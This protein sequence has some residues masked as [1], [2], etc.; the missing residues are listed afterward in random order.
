MQIKGGV[1]MRKGF[2][3]LAAIFFLVVAASIGT[4]ALSIA[5]TS[6]RQS[7]EIYLREQAQLIAQS[8]AEYAIYEIFRTNFSNK[9]LDKVSG[10]FNDMFDFNVDIT[11]FGDI[12]I[13]TPPTV[14]SGTSG[15]A[16]TGN[17]MLDV[18]VTS[19]PG[20]ALNPINFHKRTLQKL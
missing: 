18:Y 12:G 11:Y 8:A 5:S 13:C 4:L 20:K 2:T 6:A 15:I 7:S 1:L 10:E 3:L 17:V 9:C 14:M 16:S 19:K